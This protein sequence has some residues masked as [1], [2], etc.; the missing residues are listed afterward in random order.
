MAPPR[1]SSPALTSQHSHAKR[2]PIS[3]VSPDHAL[4]HLS[5]ALMDL[6]SIDLSLLVTL[7][8]PIGPD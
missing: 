3:P 8:K 7:P 4:E 6:P 1:S 5:E 2:S